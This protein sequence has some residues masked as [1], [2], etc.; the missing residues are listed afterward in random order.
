MRTLSEVKQLLADGNIEEAKAAIHQLYQENPNDTEILNTFIETEW[1]WVMA[2]QPEANYIQ[3]NILPYIHKLIQIENDNALK[4]QL[5]SY[6]DFENPVISEEDILGYL[7]DLK[8]DPV[9]EAQAVDLYIYYYD[10]QDRPEKL[11]EWID[12]G[13]KNYKHFGDNSREG[14]DTQMS[15]YLYNK[16]R[17]L[18]YHNAPAME[19]TQL[20][21]EHAHNMLIYNEFQYFEMAEFLYENGEYHLLGKIL[22][23][24]VEL[25]NTEESVR[26]ELAMWERRIDKIL[27]NGFE[28]EKLMYYVLLIQ[29]NYGEL[30]QISEA[31]HFENCQFYIAEY[32]HSK[33]PYHFAGT[34]KFNEGNYNESLTYFHEALQQGG[35]ATALYRWLV[36][37]YCVNNAF[38]ELKFSISDIPNEWY[39]NGV[40]FSEFLDEADISKDVNANE[41]LIFFYENAY[42]GLEAYFNENL[43]ESHPY[44]SLHLWA[45]CCNNLAIAYTRVNELDQAERTALKGLE[46]SEFYELHDTL[47]SIYEKQDNDEGA[48]EQYI[49][50]ADDYGPE[51][52]EESK[53]LHY[54]AKKIKYLTI[55]GEQENALEVLKERLHNYDAFVNIHGIT[56]ANSND[57]HNTSSALEL[58]ISHLAD[59][60]DWNQKIEFWNQIRAEFPNNSNVYYMLMQLYNEEG[61]YKE[62][63]ASG[64]QFLA[65]KN[66][67]WLFEDDKIKAYYQIG[68]NASFA[69]DHQK[70]CKYLSEILPVLRDNESMQDSENTLLFY[71]VQSSQ[72]TKS[73]EQTIQWAEEHEASYDRNGYDRDEDWAMIEVLKS[74]QLLNLKKKEEAL[75]NIQKILSV[76][77]NDE[78]AIALHKEL[79]KKGGFFSKWF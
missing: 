24:V 41:I 14:L 60:L 51:Y 10:T 39:N 35:S 57:L 12:Y 15:K 37:Y 6:L 65:L 17:Y 36:S 67:N 50:L 52:F 5:L 7:N 27:R 22:G 69:N 13:L 61:M 55:L 64:E 53:Y 74:Q 23:K 76:F 62:S 11:L 66:P 73:A 26:A 3:D 56:E 44:T 43:Y 32:P 19:I 9:F 33:W 30:N 79:N 8:N 70:A 77:P 46:L 59:D 54:D 20:L 45:M 38:P 42:R 21:K 48:K 68:K 34:I 71:L 72:H 40:C 47:S 58:G 78:R 29:K 2:N 25:E 16:F 1:S 4:S 28:D 31:E 49:I 18:K 63:V 75:E